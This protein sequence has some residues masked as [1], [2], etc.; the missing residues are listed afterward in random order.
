MLLKEHLH[1]SQRGEATRIAKALGVSTSYLSQLA[2]GTTNVSPSRCIEIEALTLSAV[3]RADLR[4][5]DWQKIWPDYQATA[6]QS[7]G[8]NHGEQQRANQSQV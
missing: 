7:Q 3:T 4:P 6:N 1:R 2:S 8:V 5:F